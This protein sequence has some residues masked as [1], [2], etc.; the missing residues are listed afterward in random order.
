M[1][2]FFILFI[3]AYT[4]YGDQFHYNS[5]LMGDRAI[6]LGGAFCGVSDDASG[7]FYNPAGLSFSLSSGISGS[8]NAFYRK[9]TTYKDAFG[10]GNDFIEE[11]GGSIPTFAGGMERLDN[12][13]DDLTFAFGIFTPDSE[14]RNQEDIKVAKFGH[15]E[16][17]RFHRGVVQNASTNYFATALAYRFNRNLS[18]GFALSMISIDELI[19]EYQDVIQ[20][21]YR[22]G[23]K[24]LQILS[25]NIKH[26]LSALAVEPSFSIQWVYGTFS[27]GVNMKFPQM[28]Y[29]ELDVAL[30]KRVS[31]TDV[32]DKAKLDRQE[33]IEPLALSQFIKH[34]VYLEK[35]L[36]S[37]PSSLR[38]GEPGFRQ[39]VFCFQETLFFIAV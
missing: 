24:Y 1:K 34:S 12:I 17:H 4:L 25:Q 29:Q 18:I 33:A 3:F 32:K 5:Y 23:K 26:R 22:D 19:Q 8:A 21:I 31:V 10:K 7:I 38:M 13:S 15:I 11:S 37:I 9:T 28:I 20:D 2:F 35:P 30:E 27:F 16:I 39:R 14:F 36:G 6:G